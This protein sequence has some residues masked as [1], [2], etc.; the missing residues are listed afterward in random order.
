MPRRLPAAGERPRAAGAPEPG[1]QPAE[2][3]ALDLPAG[4]AKPDLAIGPGAAP[5][6]LLRGEPWLADGPPALLRAQRPSDRRAQGA[7]AVRG[8]EAVRA[9][10]GDG[11]GT[12]DHNP[13]P[14]LWCQRR[15]SRAG[16]HGFASGQYRF[17]VGYADR[18][19]HTPD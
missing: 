6:L 16:E 13:A 10:H 9:L 11:N 15:D 14:I 1:L 2:S 3:H 7:R 5:G 4:L 8:V 19:S 12:P 17:M 18:R